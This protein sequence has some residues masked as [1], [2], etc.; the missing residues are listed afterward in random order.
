MSILCLFSDL[1]ILREKGEGHVELAAAVGGSDNCTD[2]QGMW[3]ELYTISWN[4]IAPGRAPDSLA[5]L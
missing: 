1:G 5:C 2:Q 4:L 3:W